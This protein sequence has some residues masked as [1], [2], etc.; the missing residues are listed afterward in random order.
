MHGKFS[1]NTLFFSQCFFVVQKLGVLFCRDQ[2]LTHWLVF[3][4]LIM[5]LL[6]VSFIA[7]FPLK[8]FLKAPLLVKKNPSHWLSP[9]FILMALLSVA[10][11]YPFFFQKPSRFSLVTTREGHLFS[12]FCGSFSL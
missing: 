5:F 3:P 2:T 4:F 12:L 9:T 6:F 7:R 1:Q 11:A 10:S 8:L